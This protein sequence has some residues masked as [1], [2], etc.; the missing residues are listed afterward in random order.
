MTFKADTFYF[1]VRYK[2]LEQY[3]RIRKILLS[4]R[5]HCIIS[6]VDD[7]GYINICVFNVFR[8]LADDIKSDCNGQCLRQLN[9]DTV[10]YVLKTL[11]INFSEYVKVIDNFDSYDFSD[12]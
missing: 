11:D 2:S 7:N 6:D 5:I 4:Y 12:N 3:Y 10:Q 8:R 9:D 1:R